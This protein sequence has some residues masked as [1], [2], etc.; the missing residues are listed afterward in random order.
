[1]AKIE[2][3]DDGF[4]VRAGDTISFSYGIPPRGVRGVLFERDGKLI[5]PSPGHNPAEATLGQI[6]YHT[7]GFYKVHYPDRE[8]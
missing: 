3:D 8:V 1:M 7:G 5:C 2:K 4:E 6:R